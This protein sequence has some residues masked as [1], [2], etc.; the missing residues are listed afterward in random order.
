MCASERPARTF[1]V[2]IRGMLLLNL[3][4]AVIMAGVVYVLTRENSDE[5]YRALVNAIVA[6]P[7]VLCPLTAVILRSGPRRDLVMRMILLWGYVL[8]LTL[9]SLPLFPTFRYWLF[10]TI[11]MRQPFFRPKVSSK[12]SIITT[13]IFSILWSGAVYFRLRWYPKQCP[14]CQRRGL[15]KAFKNNLSAYSRTHVFYWCAF[16]GVKLKHTKTRPIVWCDASSHEEKRFY[17]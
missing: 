13:I 15:I 3:Y 6:I 16:C 14:N 2:T 5:K 12:E 9:L 10:D 8:Y 1:R 4:A 11:G 17:W 7:G